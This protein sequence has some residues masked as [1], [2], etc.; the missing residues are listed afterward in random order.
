MSDAY[1]RFD[2]LAA[3]IEAT[4]FDK[5]VLREFVL[6]AQRAQAAADEALVKWLLSQWVS[7]LEPA[8]AWRGGRIVGLTL[9][10]YQPGDDAVIVI[11]V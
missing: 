5:S 2:E 4:G 8:V 11:G 9:A 10:D 6:R 1:D 7:E 3:D